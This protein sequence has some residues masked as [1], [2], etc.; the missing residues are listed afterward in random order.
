M[1]LGYEKYKGITDRFLQTLLSELGKKEILGCALFGSVARGTAKENSDIDLFLLLS[2]KTPEIEKRI[3]NV[4]LE[5]EYWPEKISLENEGLLANITIV[6]KTYEELKTNPLILLDIIEEG[7]VL[8]DPDFKLEEIFKKFK[9]RLKSLGAQKITLKDGSW[10]WD[11]KPDW[12]P[13]EIVE[14]TL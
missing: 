3:I 2:E 13:G 14:I 6:A 1:G 4:L 12:K 11:L 9:D 7:I 10:Y 8:Y 5:A